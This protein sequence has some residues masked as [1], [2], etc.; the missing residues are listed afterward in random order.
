VFE[1]AQMKGE[2]LVLPQAGHNDVAEIGGDAYWSWLGRAIGDAR[3][4]TTPDARAETRSA[5]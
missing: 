5:P 1:A 4:A 2:L 3:L